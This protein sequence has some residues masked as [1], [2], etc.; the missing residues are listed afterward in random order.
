[1]RQAHQLLGTYQPQPSLLHKSPLWAKGL[2]L[3]GLTIFLA[4]SSNWVHTSFALLSLLF[5]GALCR[6]PWKNW[7]QAFTSLVWIILI[8][9]AYYIISGK[10]AQGADALLTLLTM[11]AASRLLLWSTPLPTLI[12]GLIWL[13]RPLAF[14]GFNPQQLG[15]ILALMIRSIP[16]I[17]DHWQ[18]IQEAAAARGVR[19]PAYRLF[20][21]LVISTVGYAQQTGDALAARGLDS[22]TYP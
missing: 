8:L 17:F 1:M 4:I 16:V 20:I 21:P 10:L 11:I 22:P 6:Y 2:G 15:L 13:A 5:V 14:C 12:D 3:L 18:I 19:I 9:L 7:V